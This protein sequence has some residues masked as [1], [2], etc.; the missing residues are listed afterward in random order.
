VNREAT[1]VRSPVRAST[2]A[3]PPA[4][5]LLN[6][7]DPNSWMKAKIFSAVSRLAPRSCAP[8]TKSIRRRSMMSCFFL[9]MALMQA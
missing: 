9:L 8:R 5:H 7:Y 2:T 6:P 1:V 3:V 4:R